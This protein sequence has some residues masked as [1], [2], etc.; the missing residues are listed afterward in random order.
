MPITD[1]H[2]ASE[3]GKI[4]AIHTK[5]G[6]EC[7]IMFMMKEGL[8]KT[9]R[10]GTDPKRDVQAAHISS[11]RARIC[12]SGR[13]AAVI[14]SSD[15]A[16]RAGSLMRVP[17]LCPALPCVGNPLFAS[18]LRLA[19]PEQKEEPVLPDPRPGAANPG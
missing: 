9:L 10:G 14:G 8:P 18:R 19:P 2:H 15:R 5:S 1:I 11:N 3:I 13:R 17:H 16:Y 12:S 7:T 6:D 4:M